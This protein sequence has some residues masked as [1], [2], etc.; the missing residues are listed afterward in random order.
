MEDEMD[1]A[2]SMHGEQRRPHRILVGKLEGRRPLRGPRHKWEDN[3]KMDLRDIGW[4]G[5]YCLDLAQ[6]RDKC[7]ALVKTLMNIWV[8]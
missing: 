3:I 1:R 6:D 7:R 5:T 4:G 2:C 8:P